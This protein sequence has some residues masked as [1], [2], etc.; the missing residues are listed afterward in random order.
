MKNDIASAEMYAIK[1]IFRGESLFTNFW[2]YPVVSSTLQNIKMSAS[3]GGTEGISGST[4]ISFNVGIGN[5]IDPNLNTAILSLYDEE[6]VCNDGVDCEF[7]KSLQPIARPG[8]ITND[9]NLYSKRENYNPFFEILSAEFWIFMVLGSVIVLSSYFMNIGNLTDEKCHFNIILESIGI[10]MN[11]IPFLFPYSVEDN[12]ANKEFDDQLKNFQM[13]VM[14]NASGKSLIWIMGFI[15]N[16]SKNHTTIND[17]FDKSTSNN[18]TMTINTV[19]TLETNHTGKSSA[20]KSIMSKIID[21]HYQT[22]PSISYKNTEFESS[23][24]YTSPSHY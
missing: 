3:P 21:Y 11:F 23:F 5:K 1:S 16:E 2:I 10:T 14:N 8:S 19:N 6:E 9:Y 17:S 24:P 15:D 12:M 4:F 13:C 20:R 7:F 18:V 22:D